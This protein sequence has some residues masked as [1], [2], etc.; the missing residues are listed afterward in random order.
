M[1]IKDQNAISLQQ[2]AAIISDSAFVEVFVPVREIDGV[3]V[4]D[5]VELILDKR[6][7]E[8]TLSGTVAEIAHD[9]E[10]KLS[11]LG[12]EERK[13]RVL[14]TPDSESLQ[15]GYTVDA[16]FTVWSSKDAVSV[17]KTAIFSVDGE[18]CVWRVLNGAL[19]VAPVEK[20]VELQDAYVIASGLA[21]G[22]VVVLDA[23]NAALAEGKEVK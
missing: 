14:I 5:P 10:L 15:I 23:D 22:D 12:V 9:A 20:S 1:L 17:P 19:N 8:E 18:D 3:D 16:K 11:P 6:L 2:P 4:G 13:V 7:G 21:A